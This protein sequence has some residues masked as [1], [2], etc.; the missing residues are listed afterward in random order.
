[1]RGGAFACT[2]RRRARG[3]VIRLAAILPRRLRSAVIFSQICSDEWKTTALQKEQNHAARGHSERQAQEQ[4]AI[5]HYDD[6][7]DREMVKDPPSHNGECEPGAEP[8]GRRK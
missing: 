1:M 6:A 8:C 5:V 4:T 2:F 3:G 7:E